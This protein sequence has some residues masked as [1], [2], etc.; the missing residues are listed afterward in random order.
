MR[1]V[2][3]KTANNTI[4]G[5]QV[6]KTCHTKEKYSTW[7]CNRT[8]YSAQQRRKVSD[9][10][11]KQND[12]GNNW[13]SS[14]AQLGRSTKTQ[15]IWGEK[16]KTQGRVITISTS[17]IKDLSRLSTW[18]PV[19][20]TEDCIHPYSNYRGRLTERGLFSQQKRKPQGDIAAF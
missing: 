17:L 12:A 2:I 20:K 18:T 5:T 11:R 8:K 10:T 19:T 14:L 6:T 16:K 3:T 9:K 1:N 15:Q 4:A 7:E 13:D